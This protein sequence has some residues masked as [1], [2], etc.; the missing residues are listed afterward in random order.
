MAYRR[1]LI[2][3]LGVTSCLDVNRLGCRVG[4]RTGVFGSGSGIGDTTADG[5]MT[6][7]MGDCGAGFVSG[8]NAPWDIRWAVTA[9]A[10][11][12]AM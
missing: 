7:D 3:L 12:R 6:I 9:S 4:E 2:A 8:C 5:D 11:I 10:W 1:D